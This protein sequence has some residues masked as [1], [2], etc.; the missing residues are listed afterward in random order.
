MLGEL[1]SDVSTDGDLWG[2]LADPSEDVRW[3]AAVLLAPTGDHRVLLVLLDALKSADH[4]RR[5]TVAAA[6]ASMTEDERS[7]LASLAA[8]QPID[9][10]SGEHR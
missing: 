2:A 8:G 7:R 3:A 10:G 5:D 1:V 4:F 9:L 6:L